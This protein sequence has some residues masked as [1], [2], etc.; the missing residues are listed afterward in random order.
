MQAHLTTI[1]VDGEIDFLRKGRSED[2][3]RLVAERG[4]GYG[5]AGKFVVS[6]TGDGGF[7]MMLGEIETPRRLGSI[8]FEIE[9]RQR[10]CMFNPSGQADFAIFCFST[11]GP[12]ARR[13]SLDQRSH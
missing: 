9:P 5:G 6:L 12:Y 10:N 8:E 11:L 2:H 4:A 7:N 3:N 13:S 1:I